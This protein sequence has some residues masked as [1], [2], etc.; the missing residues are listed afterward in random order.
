MKADSYSASIYP[1]DVS[2]MQVIGTMGYK[3]T[4]QI[5]SRDGHTSEDKEGSACFRF[6][7]D[8]P[9]ATCQLFVL[10]LPHRVM[11]SVGMCETRRWEV[12]S[13]RGH[14]AGGVRRWQWRLF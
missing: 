8:G 5:C 7:L 12:L 2:R 6:L 14:I 11:V 9:I 10:P 4:G 1:H 13:Y 3:L